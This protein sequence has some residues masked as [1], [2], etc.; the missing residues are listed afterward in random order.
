MLERTR[1]VASEIYEEISKTLKFYLRKIKIRELDLGV[2]AGDA[3]VELHT[4]NPQT[5]PIDLSFPPEIALEPLPEA[6]P[7]ILDIDLSYEP[8]YVQLLTGVGV[9]VQPLV[10]DELVL[11]TT[12][13]DVWLRSVKPIYHMLEE[14]ETDNSEVPIEVLKTVVGTMEKFKTSVKSGVFALK[15]RAKT[16]S[17][18]MSFARSIPMRRNRLALHHLSEEQHLKLWRH[19]LNET[20]LPPERLAILGVFDN[21][22][23]KSVKKVIAQEEGKY[24][25]LYLKAGYTGKPVMGKLILA[26]DKQTKELVK[27]LMVG[28]S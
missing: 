4:F 15:K 26:R 21:I 24:V 1:K 28:E 13:P 17:S 3:Q 14:F 9:N 5:A 11:T 22:P 25:N 16:T 23:V 12:S 2:S 18:K 20:R 8:K 27:S 10:M 19:L 7:I 6:E